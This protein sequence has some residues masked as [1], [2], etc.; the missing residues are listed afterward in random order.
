M[1]GHIGLLDETTELD[2][3][4]AA[5]ARRERE[6]RFL[7]L[8]GEAL[9]ES[10][11]YRSTLEA[12]AHMAAGSIAD[13]CVVELA[14]PTGRLTRVASEDA[15]EG[16]CDDLCE[17]VEG[18]PEDAGNWA[19]TQAMAER[20]VVRVDAGDLPT[21]D[22]GRALRAMGAC[23]VIVA[24]MQVRGRSIGVLV[25][26]WR[27]SDGGYGAER[28]R[29]AEEL[30]RRSAMAIDNARLH[31]EAQ[32]A[33]RARDETLAIVAHD[34]R[35]PL[36]VISMTAQ[37]VREAEPVGPSV[38]ARM[39]SIERAA[40][41][42]DRLIQD[43]LE[44]ARIEAGTL[45]MALLPDRADAVLREAADS[46]APLAHSAGITLE[47]ATA[48]DLPRVMAD[49]R[50]LIQA[51]GNLAGNAFKFT[52]RGGRVTLAAEPVA[53]GVRLGVR[54]TGAGIEP[55]HLAHL[56]D[57]FWQKQAGDARGVGLGLAIAQGIVAAH[58]S[59][60]EVESELG[61]GTEFSFVLPA[62]AG[63]TAVEGSAA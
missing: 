27:R 52:P 24:P 39:E 3:D 11:D 61:R 25:L 20:R 30:A 44:A 29:L 43:L 21:D 32:R 58:G 33:I 38:V 42:M 47:M 17:A 22:F 16:S 60:I 59:R 50:R 57:R 13:F 46:L 1:H 40:S 12:V 51:L 62:A 26:G 8:A 15:E 49:R 37:L 7:A 9:A 56:F 48:P 2:G 10:L 63:A 14:D 5:L 6:Q 34:L 53:E 41:R 54:D 35:N 23:S 18:W 36:G 4:F 19:V 28:M 45:K 55:E 31:T